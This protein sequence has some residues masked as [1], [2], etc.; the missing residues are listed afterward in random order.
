M[1]ARRCVFLLLALLTI[2]CGLASRRFGLP[3]LLGDALWAT[4]IFWLS[5]AARP[6]VPTSR[7]ALFALLVSF[8]VEFSQLYHVRW[9][10][11]IRATTAGHLILGAGFAGADLAAYGAGVAL[12]VVG[13]F[14]WTR[15]FT[16]AG[17][18]AGRESW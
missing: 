7:A 2:A 8:A 1:V 18:A 12:G 4:L 11:D 14:G 5:R 10:D 17:R 16:R 3:K 9:L 15:A 6:A 13:E